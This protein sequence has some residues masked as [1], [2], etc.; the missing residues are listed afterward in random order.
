MKFHTKVYLNYFRYQIP[1][2]CFCE[3][4]GCG[5]PANDIN[6][7]YARGMGGNPSGDKDKIEN[8]MATC[9]LHHIEFGD[10]PEKKQWLKEVHL[11]FMKNNC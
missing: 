5:L 7:I 8:L 6:H 2:D 1:E 10:V 4:P 9:R 3:I 11:E